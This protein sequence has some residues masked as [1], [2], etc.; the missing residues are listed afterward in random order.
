[1]RPAG[2]QQHAVGAEGQRIAERAPDVGRVGQLLEPDE[3]PV[4]GGGGSRQLCER[5]LGAALGEREAALVDVI[6]RDL[7]KQC[8]LGQQD[9]RGLDDRSQ[10][11]LQIRQRRRHEQRAHRSGR[12]RADAAPRGG[13]ATKQPCSRAGALAQV[14][15]W[16]A[17]VVER[18]DRSGHRARS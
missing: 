13:S 8:V 7:A 9:G 3:Q 6:A 4:A 1:V 2:R 18:F 10:G 16:H 14:A 17:R 11:V 12:S 5:G 15:A